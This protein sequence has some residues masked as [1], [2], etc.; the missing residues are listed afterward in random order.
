MGVQTTEKKMAEK[1]KNN[2]RTRTV[3]NGLKHDEDKESGV[4]RCLALVQL[5]S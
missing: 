5:G 1:I 4:S 3:R 2:L